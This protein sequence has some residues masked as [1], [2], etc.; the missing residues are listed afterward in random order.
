MRL[1][2]A[3]RDWK[4]IKL[5]PIGLTKEELHQHSNSKEQ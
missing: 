4:N 3:E 2:K 1:P 5:Q